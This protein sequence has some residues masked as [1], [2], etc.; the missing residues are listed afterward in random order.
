M[1][2][3][4]IGTPDLQW[5]ECWGYVAPDD[6][7]A[8]QILPECTSILVPM[9]WERPR[10][11]RRIAI[12]LAR[13]PATDPSAR[14]GTLMFN[15]GGPMPAIDNIGKFSATLNKHFDIGQSVLYV[16]SS[17]TDEWFSHYGS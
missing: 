3:V 12:A 9:D 10:A 8:E 14:V 1:L 7:K 16:Q 13:I 6:R 17:Y 4:A 5:S 11:N 2:E 15:P